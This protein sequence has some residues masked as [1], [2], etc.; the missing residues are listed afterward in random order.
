[1]LYVV[2]PARVNSRQLSFRSA[3]AQVYNPGAFSKQFYSSPIK[4]A[5]QNPGFTAR[6]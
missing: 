5:I 2:T 1:M 6:R 4:A 3:A